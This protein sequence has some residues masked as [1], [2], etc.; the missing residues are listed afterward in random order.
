MPILSKYSNEQV[1]QLV[2]A[3]LETLTE[4]KANVDLSLMSLGN[5]VTHILNTH[6][7]ANKRLEVA[8]SFAEALK[9][10]IKSN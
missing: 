10:S 6:V 2:S 9:S 1:E 8:T 3:L 4:Q 7:P 5:A